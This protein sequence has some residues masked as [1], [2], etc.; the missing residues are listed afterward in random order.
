MI[1][2]N[3]QAQAVVL[4]ILVGSLH[5]RAEV[6]L[7]NAYYA[8]RQTG[9]PM[10]HSSV[11]VAEGVF[12]LGIFDLVVVSLERCLLRVRSSVE[13]LEYFAVKWLDRLQEVGTL[14]IGPE[15]LRRHKRVDV[16]LH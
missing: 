14:Q 4:A 6:L 11:L 1:T 2:L 9:L 10:P 5:D 8:V 16:T 13:L 7:V 15:W 3:I 12:P